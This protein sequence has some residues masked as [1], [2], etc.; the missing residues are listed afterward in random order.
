MRKLKKGETINGRAPAVETDENAVTQREVAR[1]FAKLALREPR[2]ERL[3]LDVMRLQPTAWEWGERW[4]DQVLPLVGHDRKEGPEHLK[5]DEAYDVVMRM[6]MIYL[7]D[8]M[9]YGETFDEYCVRAEKAE[10]EFLAL[11]K[12]R[13]EE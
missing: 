11:L 3:L 6:C 2:L 8:G 12:E 13:E 10:Q 5:T 4:Y 9:S 1:K 7:D